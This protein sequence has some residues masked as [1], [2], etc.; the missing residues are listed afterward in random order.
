MWYLREYESRELT[1]NV[2][3][4][5]FVCISKYLLRDKQLKI[6]IACFFPEDKVASV[7]G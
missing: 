3:F 5:C 6:K 7:Y 2:V 4:V 1:Y